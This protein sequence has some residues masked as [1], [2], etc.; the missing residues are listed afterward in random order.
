ML[1]S[2][3]LYSVSITDLGRPRQESNLLTFWVLLDY[4]L[5]PRV[6]CSYLAGTNTWKHFLCHKN[7]VECRVK[8]AE[9]A[10][11]IA[12]HLEMRDKPS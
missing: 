6:L 8:E 11:A 3:A 12:N 4:I 9:S 5:H 2:Y 10:L 1:E 7:V